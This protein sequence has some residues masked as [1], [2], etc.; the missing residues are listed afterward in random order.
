M[1]GAAHRWRSVAR[2][3]RITRHPQST[4]KVATPSSHGMNAE[5]AARSIGEKSTTP[6]CQCVHSE[7]IA[8]ANEGWPVTSTITASPWSGLMRIDVLMAGALAPS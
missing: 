3:R 7:P 1:L 6:V 5:R 4:V 2:R 8:L